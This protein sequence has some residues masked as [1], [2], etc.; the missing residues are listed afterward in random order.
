MTGRPASDDGFSLIELLVAILILGVVGGATFTVVL[1]AQRSQRFTEQVQA[2]TDDARLSVERIRQQLRMARL[3]TQPS[4]PSGVRFWVDEN[5]DGLP[6]LGEWL[7]Y[8]TRQVEPG[9]YELVRWNDV[10]A[11]SPPTNG[12]DCSNLTP[13]ADAA[14]LARTLRNLD[15]FQYSVTS[16][17]FTPLANP[18]TTITNDP[19]VRRVDVKLEFDVISDSG[20]QVFSTGTKVRLRNV[21]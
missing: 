10:L 9:R 15:V 13:P 11:T 6:D 4:G 7:C 14:V 2:A 16:A 3:V 8:A 18:A 5:Q 19:P 17:G 12:T 21:P 20:P 1:S